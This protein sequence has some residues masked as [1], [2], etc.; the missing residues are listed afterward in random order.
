MKRNAWEKSQIAHRHT[1][2]FTTVDRVHTKYKS[3]QLDYN[4]Q[5]LCNLQRLQHKNSKHFNTRQ[6][7]FTQALLTN[8]FY[9][10][11]SESLNQQQLDCPLISWPCHQ[12][13]NQS[14]SRV[15]L[16]IYEA[17]STHFHICI[18]ILQKNK[19]VSSNKKNSSTAIFRGLHVQANFE[20]ELYSFK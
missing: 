18:Q 4:T 9:L 14:C 6:H 15:Y 17:H 3:L 5:A 19:E 7:C 13:C 2:T 10:K 16:N 20:I 8:F 12:P 1:I 11:F